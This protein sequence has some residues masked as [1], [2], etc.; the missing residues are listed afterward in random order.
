M[1]VLIF[2]L[3]VVWF[4]CVNAI[5]VD[6]EAEYNER[7]RKFEWYI[8]NDDLKFFPSNNLESWAPK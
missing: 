4:I 2:L 1:L 3:V 8:K 6:A 5:L 7:K